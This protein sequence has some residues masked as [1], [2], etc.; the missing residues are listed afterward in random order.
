[1][2]VGVGKREE[3][4]AGVVGGAVAALGGVIVVWHWRV[5]WTGMG[6]PLLE[7]CLVRV[8]TIRRRG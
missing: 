2:F 3:D 7:A 5:G 1:M 6:Q 4:A 8:I